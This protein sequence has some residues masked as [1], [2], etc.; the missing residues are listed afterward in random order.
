MDVHLAYSIPFL[1]IFLLYSNDSRLIDYLF[2]LL[3]LVL[4]CFEVL[5]IYVL[6]DYSNDNDEVVIKAGVSS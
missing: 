1:I 6:S 3:R 4:C 5:F 2:F